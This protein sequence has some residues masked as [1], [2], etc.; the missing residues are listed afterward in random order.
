LE[1][2]TKAEETLKRQEAAAARLSLLQAGPREEELAV[3]KAAESA[4][5]ARVREIT[6]SL[7]RTRLKAPGA[8]RILRVLRHEGESVSGS[9]GAA[10]V[11]FAD[12][13]SLQVR[14]EVDEGQAMSVRP[15]LAVQF[16]A[17]GIPNR[18]YTGKVARVQDSMGRK[19]LLT[20][21]PRQKVD[22]RVVEIIVEL[23]EQDGLRIHQRVDVSI[24]R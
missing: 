20:D 5:E 22:T 10:V 2:Q 11:V 13:R 1:V 21:D 8:G 24:P 6:A 14:A 9:D 4:A 19:N 18:V 3:A 15:G 23:Q 12:T 16:T 17:R 7:E